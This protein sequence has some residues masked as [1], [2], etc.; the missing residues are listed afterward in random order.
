MGVTNF[1]NGVASYGVPIV[2]HPAAS[3]GPV[4]FVCNATNA[5]GSDGNSGKDPDHP[6]AT[7]DAAIGLCSTVHGGTIHAMPGHAET[8]TATSIAHDVA[9][10][11]VIGHGY[12]AS[13]PTFTFGAA[14]AT[15][16]VSAAGGSWSNCHLKANFLDVASA[17]TIGAAKDFHVD[18]C[19]FIDTSAILN[20]LSAVT[21]GSTANAADGLTV[22]G[23]YQLGLNT[24]PL[25][26]IS[27]LG[28]LDRL[29]VAH[30]FCDQASTADVGCFI[31]IAAL[32]I[33]GAHIEWNQ[34]NVVGS[35][36]AAVAVFITGSSTTNTGMVN[37]N[38]VTSL[39]TTGA[40]LI[41]AAIGLAV[42]ENY[43]SGVVAASGTLFPAADNPA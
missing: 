1:P 40:L 34:L 25:A 22:T 10:V 14:A 6:L 39:D 31:T 15:I 29:Y 8:V 43:M 28:N 35:T 4:F 38:F 17:F 23:N 13:R 20:F 24:S 5:N 27:I 11:H 12:G 36:G 37:N 30:N 21:T 19:S 26:F 32:V 16:T 2:P 7:V 3:F 18:G 33:L 42:H 9:N 41:T